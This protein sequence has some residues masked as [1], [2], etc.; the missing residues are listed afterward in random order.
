[1]KEIPAEKCCE[2]C[3][4]VF[5][6]RRAVYAVIGGIRFC[7]GC[8]ADMPSWC[9]ECLE[10]TPKQ[11]VKPAAF[12]GGKLLCQAHLDAIAPPPPKPL[13][14]LAQIASEELTGQKI[15][16]KQEK[17]IMPAAK[18][19]DW[20]EVQQERNGGATVT[21]LAEKYGCSVP[22]VCNHTKSAKN[23]SSPVPRAPRAAKSP[24]NGG[25]KFAAVVEQMKIE[26]DKLD[27]AI[28]VLE[29]F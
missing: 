25:G 5:G 27:A 14:T 6:E 23:G 21:A 28:R 10:M 18:Q 3:L 12:R 20:D 26:R 11:W 13:P 9:I 22:T 24:A 8:I 1:M 29:A 15:E 19:I 2:P 17:K 7:G 16:T 4:T